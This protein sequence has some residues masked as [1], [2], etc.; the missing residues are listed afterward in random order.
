MTVLRLLRDIVSHLLL[1]FLLLSG[2]A[3]QAAGQLESSVRLE[4][5][6]HEFIFSEGLAVGLIGSYGR[7]AVYTDL[8]AWQMATGDFKVPSEGLVIGT[9]A[10]GREQA[11]TPAEAD[12]NGLIR[13]RG[14]RG[15]YLWCDVESETERTMV[16]EASGHYV[17][18]VNGEPR[19][20]EKYGY[21]WVRHPVRLERGRNTFLFRAERG[22]IRA[23]LFDPPAPVFFTDSDLTL[24][25]LVIGEKGPVQAGI[26]LV[27][28]TGDRLEQIEISYPDGAGR[29]VTAWTEAVPPFMTRKLAVPLTLDRP[30]VAG[31]VEITLRGRYRDGRQVRDIPSFTIIL[32]AVAPE[33]H[34]SRTFISDID[35][36]VQYFSVSPWTGEETIGS[37]GKPALFLTVH[38]AG[39]EAINQA[40]AYDPKSWGWVV[41]ATNRRPYG[42]DWEDWGR[43]DALEVLDEAERLFGT[44]PA[45]T[46]LTG[47]SMGGHGT[48][49]IGATFPDRWAAIG[50]S[51]GWRSF[52]SYGGGITYENPTPVEAML[53]RAA[54]PGDTEDLSR[55]YLHHGVYILHGD[56]D[57]NVP[58][59]QARFMR[60]LL[61][62]FHA[63]FSYYERPGAGHWWGD[64]CV[65]W[66][67]MFEFFR[68]HERPEDS[69][70]RRVEF[71][72]ADPGISS[73]SHWLTIH[74][75]IDPLEFSRVVLERNAEDSSI[76][77]TT[78]NVA[79]LAL[80]LH[81]IDPDS[82]VTITLD[83]HELPVAVP[84]SVTQIY[85][86]RGEDSWRKVPPPSAGLKS[87]DRSGRFKDAFR[88]RV[89]LVYGTGGE[90]EEDAAGY[91]KAR[92]DAEMFWYRGNGSLDVVADTDFD[93]A[94][95]PD[96][97]VI[98]YGNA[99]TNAHWQSLLGDGPVQVGRRR[100]TVGE[101]RFRGR[102]MGCYFIRP[103]PDSDTAT[104]G[105]VAWT[106][107]AGRIAAGAG[108]YFISGAGYPDLMIFSADML[109][110]G[111]G[112][113]RMLGFFG[114]DWSVEEGDFVW[115]M[116]PGIDSD[117]GK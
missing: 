99:D 40:R 103:R 112:G 92:F 2:P 13:H 31:P 24:P 30:E 14:L 52:S 117:R 115:N 102:D 96:R 44:D 88:N 34:H 89:V 51:A 11:W 15:G 19:G 71:V 109:R 69:T 76:S 82:T 20:G 83:G 49:Q 61:A 32:Q 81:P 62:G 53:A 38:G 116:P 107:P 104:V 97:N 43:L 72:T 1:V 57:T 10:R 50:P 25:D 74:T 90:R 27:N 79:V 110:D 46:Y 73:S 93:P 4:A 17:V 65:D 26:R 42:F 101:H 111:S 9:D 100:I 16:L 106:G 63:D 41:A 18:Y 75:Q 60:E 8:L 113:I 78:E 37:A 70:V 7:S 21:D 48:W 58:V 54:H 39:V 64:E 66:P 85:L 84:E 105:A 98:L 3:G 5:G 35:G 29:S 47:H 67:P 86:E 36:S 95:D 28:T 33:A 23:R 114:P 91:A 80:D 6:S 22:Q 87:P 59:T 12:T 77:G 45:H 56:R 94:R 108:Q 68:W 55:N